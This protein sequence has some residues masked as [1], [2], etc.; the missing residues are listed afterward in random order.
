[1]ISPLTLTFIREDYSYLLKR[2]GLSNAQV[3]ASSSNFSDHINQPALDHLNFSYGQS[4][5]EGI[6]VFAKRTLVAGDYIGTMNRDGYRTMLGRSV[7]HSPLPNAR[8]EV[9]IDGI[10]LSAA[11]TIAPGVEIT[12]DYRT[13]PAVRAALDFIK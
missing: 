10:I 7:N 13:M 2:L 1:M 5:I 11:S 4:Q 12:V 8:A 9:S 6:G 3:K